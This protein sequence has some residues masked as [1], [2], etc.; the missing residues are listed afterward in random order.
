MSFQYLILF[1]MVVNF[2]NPTPVF[3][4]E[5]HLVSTKKMEISYIRKYEKSNN[6]D[7]LAYVVSLKMKQ[8]KYKFLPWSKLKVFNKQKIN[9]EEL[10]VNEPNN[11]HLRYVR[12]VIQESL[13]K[14]LNYNSNIKE[15]KE[16][17]KNILTKKDT[18]D[19]LD[20]YIL[21]NTSL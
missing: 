18:T 17:L 21:K 11:I 9:L 13:P 12:L 19:Y 8:A 15:D 14:I 1:N 7:V 16:F 3:V 20:F 2:T 5:F 4:R 10:I 6:I